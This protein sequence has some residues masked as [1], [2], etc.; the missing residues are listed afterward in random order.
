MRRRELAHVLRA[1]A[2]ITGDS[3][4]LVIGSQAI[5]GSYSEDELPDQTWVSME[6]DIAF[7][8]DPDASKAD[9]VDGHI[10]EGSEFH[11]LYAYYAQGVEVSTAVLPDGWR[12]RVIRVVDPSAAPAD[13][14]CLEKHDLV[15][16]KLMAGREKDWEFCF[17][18][19]EADLVSLGE[20]RARTLTL[21]DSR[22]VQRRAV[23]TWLDAAARK[24][25]RWV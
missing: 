21:P 17:A 3:E 7:L 18:L 15:V 20:I 19:I 11:S 13:A 10:G 12:E 9:A 8:D 5:L 24:L 1:A 6:A 14:V 2:T 25:G 16:S 4:I 23:L 22:G